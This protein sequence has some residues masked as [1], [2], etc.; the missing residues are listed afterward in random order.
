[1]IDKVKKSYVDPA[2]CL[3]LATSWD[4]SYES[5]T[6]KKLLESRKDSLKSLRD[7]EASMLSEKCYNLQKKKASASLASL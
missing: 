2:D 6:N 3:K 5:D 7:F 1:M 4:D